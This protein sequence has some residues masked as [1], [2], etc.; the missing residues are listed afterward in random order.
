MVILNFKQ[1][2]KKKEESCEVF[3]EIHLDD[4]FVCGL[5]IKNRHVLKPKKI[6]RKP[7]IDHG[8]IRFDDYLNSIK[9]MEHYK[10]D[11][12]KFKEKCEKYYTYD[13]D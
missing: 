12:E 7:K 10:C 8:V 1:C 3:K 2:V 11:I 9:Q 5:D 6:K 4:G 13:I